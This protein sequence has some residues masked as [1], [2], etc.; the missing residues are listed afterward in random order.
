MI[1]LQFHSNVFLLGVRM[2]GWFGD[3]LGRIFIGSIFTSNTWVI[4][5][6]YPH[7]TGDTYG[8]MALGKMMFK[9][10]FDMGDKKLTFPGYTTTESSHKFHLHMDGKISSFMEN[11]CASSGVK[12]SYGANSISWTRKGGRYANLL[13]KSVTLCCTEIFLQSGLCVKISCHSLYWHS[14]Q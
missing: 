2:G 6:S 10:L 3:I 13:L 14:Q 12:T 9:P 11:M 5:I 8:Y 4:F 7:A 1:T